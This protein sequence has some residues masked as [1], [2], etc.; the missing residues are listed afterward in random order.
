MPQV[1]ERRSLLISY[2]TSGLAEPEDSWLAQEIQRQALPRR[3]SG[4]LASAAPLIFASVHQH[5][6]SRVP[7]F[8]RA[9]SFGPP[10]NGQVQSGGAFMAM[11]SGDAQRVKWMRVRINILDILLVNVI[12][13]LKPYGNRGLSSSFAGIMNP[14]AN[15]RF[16]AQ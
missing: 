5:P 8:A 4:T 2:L 13:L 15:D 6:P 12:F 7:T 16:R 11:M 1:P 14:Y 9:H 10:H 3:V